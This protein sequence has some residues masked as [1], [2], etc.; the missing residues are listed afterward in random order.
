[1]R[2][3]ISLLAV[4][5]IMF[6]S[7]KQTESKEKPEV[8]IQVLTNYFDGIK[9]HDSA[10]MAQYCTDDYVLFESGKVWNNDS[11][12]NE[13]EKFK[14]IRVEFKAGNYKASIDE[15][16]GHVTYFNHGDFYSKD[17]LVSSVDWLES[18]AFKKVGDQWKI[19][20]LHSS[21]RE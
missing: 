11:L 21:I 5:T 4:Y 20:F 3:I 1:M 15:Q 12:W 19:Q 13:I 2:K 14:D 10:K 9:S 6:Y 7:C 8:L 18:A 17:S 16:S